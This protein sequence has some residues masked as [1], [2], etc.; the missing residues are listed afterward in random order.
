VSALT[1]GQPL[2]SRT[3]LCQSFVTTMKTGTAPGTQTA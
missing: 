1:F 2:S 3:P